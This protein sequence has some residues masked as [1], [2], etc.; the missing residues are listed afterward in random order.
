[1]HENEWISQNDMHKKPHQKN[2]QFH[3]Y[4]VKKTGQN[5]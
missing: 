3:S 2:I 5:K 1:M 4:K